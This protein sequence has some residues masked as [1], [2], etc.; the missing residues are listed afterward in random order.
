MAV[1]AVAFLAAFISSSM[2]APVT[3]SNAQTIA[4]VVDN[5]GYYV[6]IES[7]DI[8][9]NLIATPTGATAIASDTILTKTNSPTGYK[10]YLSV[11]NS[12]T[13]GN[14]LYK[15]GDRAGGMYI[16]PSA[17]TLSTPVPLAVNTWGYTTEANADE[18][19][20]FIGV[21]LQGE[22]NLLQS[23]STPDTT[24]VELGITYGVNANMALESG[25]YSNEI[26][27]TAIAEGEAAAEGTFSVFPNTSLI[28]GG[29]TLTIATDLYT[30]M[31]DI[32]TI[33]VSL[34]D[35]TSTYTCADPERL[36]RES[37]S[38]SITCTIPT[39]TTAGTYDVTLSLP[40]FG[41]NYEATDAIEFTEVPLIDQCNVASA[42]DTFTYDGVE[43]I[44][45]ADNNCYTHS[46]Q[47]TSTWGSTGATYPSINVC[48]A[49]TS[50]PT[51]DEF[52][53][54]ISLYG[55]SNLGSAT[56]WYIP[57]K[58]VRY[59]SSTITSATA[60][61]TAQYLYIYES[62]NVSIYSGI[63][64]NSYQ[65]VC[66]VRTP[67]NTT[68]AQQMTAN[69]CSAMNVGDTKTLT[70]T[71]D[72]NTYTMAKLAD[73]R[74]WMTQNL[75]LTGAKTLYVSDSNVA[76]DWNLPAVNT[77]F[78]TSCVDT[79]Y[80]MSSGNSTYGNYYN[81]YAATAG[82]GTCAMTSGNATASICP[83]GW[84]L[85][86]GGSSGEFQILYD[87][88]SSASA[89]MSADGPAFVLSGRRYGTSTGLQGSNGF[90]WSS[91]VY[92]ANNAYYLGLD[93][94]SVRPA[95]GYEKYRGHTVRCIA[96]N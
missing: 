94:S 82:T 72:S 26:A 65:V 63:R 17:G 61:N 40:K 90:Y 76:S 14:R 73:D 53:K 11:D 91:T 37:G 66:A 9:I 64:T 78:P 4:T 19:S 24:G 31:E 70:D 60:T 58:E 86:T 54:L 67:S 35:G 55:A 51:V 56:G 87:N 28:S 95:Y 69:I 83:K 2:C 32:G 27:Y 12:E 8:A 23:T 45:L 13:N 89:M 41:K 43:Y 96:D 79:A 47:G 93:S 10:L 75:K 62:P 42:G 38:I 57:G 16:S 68:L 46:S 34:T 29:G 71:R 22:E 6:S 33:N 30:N 3:D 52:T 92:G 7:S 18:E 5:S 81:W 88:Y 44:K 21:P 74:C 80:N 20:D 49:G 77:S 48:P 39:V 36:S 25:I 85:P 59:W 1:F 50:V 15:D 84:R